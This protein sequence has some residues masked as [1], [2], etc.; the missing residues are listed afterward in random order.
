M[1]Y[2]KDPDYWRKWYPADWISESFP[3][4]FRNWFYSLLAM[5]TVVDNSPPFLENFGY[6]TLLAEDGRE[7]HKSWGN[8]IEFNEAADKMGVDVMRWVFC[9]HKPENNLL[10]GYTR[11]DEVR[12]RF[13]IPFWNVYSFFVTYAN[14][15]EWKPDLANFDPGKPEGDTPESENPLDQWVLARLNQVVERVTYTLE[16]SDAFG[17][18]LAIEPFLEDLTNWYVRRS[19]RRFWKSEQDVDKNTAYATLYHV[20]VKLARILAPLTPFIT[21]VMYQNLVTSVNAKA[22]ESI[23]HTQWPEADQDA[24]NDKLVEQMALARQIASLGLGA[25]SQSGIK[26]RQPL[27][28]V[29]VH[30]REGQ[31]GLPEDLID[32]V[33]DEL[34]VKAFEFVHDTESLVSFRILPNNKLLGPKYGSRFPMV[35]NALS[36]IDPAR[37]AGLVESGEGLTIEVNGES[38]ELTPEEILVNTEPAEGLAVVAD[39]YVTVAINAVITPNLRSEGLAREVVR[40]IQSMRKNA[41]FN[42]EDRITT[43]YLAEGDLSEVFTSW[44]DYIKTE[45]LSTGLV[46]GG[47]PESAYVETHQV[48]GQPIHIGVVRNQ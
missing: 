30:V 19:R 44:D 42:I 46:A 3:G 36:T 12:R 39:K 47:S 4:Q 45:T 6:A 5:A 43:Y 17:A 32:I 11:A 2:R 27:S 13:L 21:E 14:L 40:R 29:L 18:T 23:H 38:F 8:A 37:V 22:F 48:D 28:K 34:N 15:D 25:R 24:L 33:S 10:F 26:V 7:M 41:D 9:A 16:N 1:G 20:L 31:T 35:Q